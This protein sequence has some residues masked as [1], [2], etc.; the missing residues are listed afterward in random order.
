MLFP[1]GE[2]R[3]ENLLTAYTDLSALLTTMQ[4]EGFSG[5]IDLA[6][7]GTEGVI[8]VASGEILNAEARKGTDSK[9]MIGQEAARHL[10]SLSHQRDGVLNVYRMA[11]DRVT[12]LANSLH[13][14]VLFKDLSSD[15]TQL[16]RL[17]QKLVEEKHNGFI[18]ILSREHKGVGILFLQ[19]GEMADLMTTS[20]SGNAVFD[21]KSIPVFLENVAKQGV[22][23]NVYRSLGKT[24]LNEAPA[25]ERGEGEGRAGVKE[26]IPILQEILSRVE[27]LVDG[28]G[29]RGTFVKEFKRSL[30][31]RSLDYPFL[32]PF[33]GEL[34][35]REGSIVFSG[36]AGPK[37]FARGI[38]ECLKTTLKH[39]EEE[40]PKNKN[41][42]MLPVRLRVEIES[43]LERYQEGMKRLGV[44]AIFPRIFQ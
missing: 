26:L 28:G 32:D 41:N 22:F 5:T 23:F 20:E 3:H 4:S 8:F 18:E 31:E 29:R 24:S 25:R 27:R 15:F 10:L 14:E 34:E 44:D 12:M 30:I 36:E 35:Y 19:D 21:K 1:K 37:E 11:A 42:K 33:A 13:S 2:V 40:L 17:I 43:S 6:F 38:G 7:P 9:R 39:L 16:D